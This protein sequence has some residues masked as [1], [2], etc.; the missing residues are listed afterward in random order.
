M[1]L[2][3]MTRKLSIGTSEGTIQDAAVSSLVEY[4]IISAILML[5]I[6]IT[7]PVVTTVFIDQPTNTLT[8]YAFMDI[9]NGMSTRMIDFYSI[10]PHYNKCTINTKF[11][12][13]DD[14]GGRDYR[15]EIVQ[16]SDRKD[17]FIVISRGDYD[18]SVSL[19]GIG[20]TQYFG[21]AGGSTT[22]SGLNR[23]EYEY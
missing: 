7:V 8:H 2:H 16:S 20:A 10:I 18:V 3:L 13:P 19:A 21:W 5:F 6:V 15:V 22:A 11:D 4:I 9:G 17:D 1:G 14:V 23:I 12:I